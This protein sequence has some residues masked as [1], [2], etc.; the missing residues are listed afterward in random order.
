MTFSFKPRRSSRSPRTAASVSTR[1]VSWKDAA[2]MNDSVA[3]EALVIPSSIG[4][5]VAPALC[6][7][8]LQLLVQS[9]AR[10]PG[11]PARPAGS[12]VS[13]GIG[14]FDLAQ[15]LA[16][17][18]LDVLVVDPHTLQAVNVLDFAHQ[19]VGQRFTPSRRRMSCGFGS[20][21]AMTSPF[22]PAHP[23]T[24]SGDATSESAPHSA[25][26]PRR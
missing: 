21:S 1:V 2:E 25:R 22:R 10:V 14:D 16:N 6:L 9:P 18:H 7:C 20:P 5:Y 17:D 12:C 24:R 26:R 15:H 23:R 3:S 8:D 13:P 11:R 4:S 19:V